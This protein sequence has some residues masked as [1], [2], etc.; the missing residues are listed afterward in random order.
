[1][2]HGDSITVDQGVDNYNVVV[3]NTVDTEEPVAVT[4][5]QSG[6]N[7]ISWDFD[8]IGE[9]IV[10]TMITQAPTT[11]DPFLDGAV[12]QYLLLFAGTN[13]IAIAGHTA[14]RE[15]DDFE[16]YLNDRIAAG[17]PLGKIVVCTM[18]PRELV[19]DVIRT[20]YNNLLIG[21]SATY[22]YQMARFDLDPNMGQAGQDSDT[23]YY[24]DGVHPTVL[25]HQTLAGIVRPLI[26]V[27]AGS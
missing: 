6:I 12:N 16:F 1:M 24:Y 7:G 26:A 14:I 3:R 11:I 4:L 19:S 10:G 9:P 21:G 18:L 25:G 8:W 27:P 2:A 20:D 23:N 22:G 13:G 5:L 15:F 17:W